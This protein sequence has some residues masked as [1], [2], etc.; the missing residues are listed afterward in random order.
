MEKPNRSSVCYKVSWNQ[1]DAPLVMN[2]W[3]SLSVAKSTKGLTRHADSPWPIQGDEA[4]TTASAPE[5]FIVTK[6]KYALKKIAVV[7]RQ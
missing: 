5:I 1:Y 4:A 2:K 6:K 3:N 7:V